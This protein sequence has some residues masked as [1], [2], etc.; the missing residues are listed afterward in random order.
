MT[1]RDVYECATAMVERSLKFVDQGRKCTAS[2]LLSLLFYA[3]GRVTSLF[4]ACARIKGAPSDDAVRKALKANLPALDELEQRLNDALFESLPRRLFRSGRRWFVALDITLIPYHGQPQRDPAEVYRGEAKS[5]TTHF[6][7]YATAY[8]M[9]RGRRCTLALVR[10]TLGMP[11]ADVVRRL[12]TLVR[13]LG[14][15]PKLLLLDRG[16]CSVDVVRYLQAARMPFLMPAPMRGRKADHPRGPSGTYV[17]AATKHSGWSRYSWRSAEGKQASV[18]VCLVRARLKARRGKR[19]RRMTLVY[20]FWGI[21]PQ[22]YQWVRQT[23][24]RRFGIESSYRQ[25]NQARLRTST[26]DPAQRLLF[27]GLALVLRNVWVWLHC[28]V[29]AQPCRGGRQLRLEALRLR[30]MLLWI[31]HLVEAE[32]GVHDETIAYA[33]SPTP[34]MLTNQRAA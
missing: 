19:G 22:S 18:Q 10:V 3:A 9:H 15:T 13:Q 12:L 34:V 4:D 25:M 7:A 33:P 24:R 32:L 16:F 17:L 11:M 1:G 14:I 23:Y 20:F 5:G 31:V 27:V 29:L 21:E 6:H 2:M 26:R 8:L 28:E 30:A